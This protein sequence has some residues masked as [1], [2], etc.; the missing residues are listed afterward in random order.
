MENTS[1]G[2]RACFCGHAKSDHK[3]PSGVIGPEHACYHAD[4]TSSLDCMCVAFRDAG[5]RPLF[6]LD[7]VDA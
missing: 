3:R 5:I 2:N 6:A 1:S 4:K 7:D